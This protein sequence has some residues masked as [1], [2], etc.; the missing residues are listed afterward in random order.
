MN[1]IQKLTA[2][3]RGSGLIMIQIHVG[4]KQKPKAAVALYQQQQYFTSIIYWQQENVQE[5]QTRHRSMIPASVRLI[6]LIL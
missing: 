1:A 2:A 3:E 5:E 4:A 6:V